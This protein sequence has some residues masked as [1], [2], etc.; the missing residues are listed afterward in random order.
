MVFGLPTFQNCGWNSGGSYPASMITSA[1]SKAAMAVSKLRIPTVLSE[2]ES[3]ND[4]IPDP[5]QGSGILS[6][7]DSLS[8]NTVGMRNFDTAIAAFESADVIMLAGYD[9]PEFQPQ[10]WNVGRP[11]TIVYVGEA[12]VGYAHNLNVNIQVLGGLKYMLKSL[13]RIGVPKHNWIS[14][15][16]DRLWEEVNSIHPEGAG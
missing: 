8:L 10:F 9:P 15:I 6:F 13:Y 11:K 14:D 2:R 7:E 3:S 5:I 16:R 12:P 4:K 1:L